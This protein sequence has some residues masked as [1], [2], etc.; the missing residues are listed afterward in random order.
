MIVRLDVSCARLY[1]R[2]AQ[3]EELQMFSHAIFNQTLAKE[4]SLPPTPRARRY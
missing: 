3:I 1:T 4:K 2:D